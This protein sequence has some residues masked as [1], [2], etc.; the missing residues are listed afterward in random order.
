[1]EKASSVLVPTRVASWVVLIVLTISGVMYAPALAVVG[2]AACCAVLAAFE[3]CNLMR[4]IGW[5]ARLWALAFSVG[6]AVIMSGHSGWDIVPE[7]VLVGVAVLLVISG[8]PYF[9][10][11]N[12][13]QIAKMILAESMGFL[14][15]GFTLSHIPWIVDDGDGRIWLLYGLIIVAATDTGAYVFGRL[16][17]RRPLA[18]AISPSKTIE[19]AIGGWVS[20]VCVSV[21]MLKVFSLGTGIWVALCV[22]AAVSA[23]GQIGDLA[24]SKLKRVAGVKDSGRIIPGQGGILDRIDSVVLV[25]PVLYHV[26]KVYIS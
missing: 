5:N 23:I 3:F 11:T 19:G 26:S 9:L 16:F 25:L 2:V 13:A 24:E 8:L 17:G 15:L 12:P 10:W 14:Y 1:V 21:L 6:T 18:P 20:G 4:R 7:A 22:G